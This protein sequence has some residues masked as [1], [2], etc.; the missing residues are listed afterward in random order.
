VTVYSETRRQILHV[1]MAG[2]AVLLRYLTWPQAAGLAG[3][4][5][6][7]NA[8]ALGRIAPAVMRETDKRGFR[9]GVL[10]Y[11]L[12]ILLLVLVF[13]HRLDIVAA[14]WG[15]M[16][17]GD[18]FATL[19]GTTFGGPRLPW[20]RRKTWTGLVAFVLAGAAGGVALCSWVAPSIQPPPSSVFTIWAPVAAA[21]IAG[22]VETLPI[23]LDDNIS[24]PVTAGSV[25]WFLSQLNWVGSVD[26]VGFDL[27]IGAVVSMPLALIAWRTGSITTGGA[28]TGLVFASIIYA[29]LYLAGLVV[30]G[31]ALALTILS[32]RVGKSRKT[33]LGIAEERGGRRGAGNVI[34]NCL[35]GTLGAVLELFSVDWGLELAGAWFVAGI[36]AGASDTVASEIGKAWRGLPRSFPMGRPVPA[37]TPGAVSLQGTVAGLAAAALM[38]APA[39]LLWLIPWSFVP[40]IVIACTA[41]AFVE[42]ALA[43][44]FE[45]GGVVD[46]HTLNFLNTAAAV[47]VA[48][49]WCGMLR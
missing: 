4:A 1:A 41:G 13:P 19:A 17:F 40:A 9:A 32:S 39:A 31:V 2:F 26:A 29:G 33:E 45:G 38:A 25:L 12:S 28:L 49:W 11:P 35:V 14:A 6:A 44:R 16:A 48:V 8:V 22:L 37:G 43:T 24:V 46:N 20:N 42:S 34:A 27:F 21:C 18:G 10:F 23:E 47:A 15:V 36:A 5:V 3:A 30:L 7:F